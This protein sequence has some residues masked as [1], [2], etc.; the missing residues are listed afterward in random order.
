MSGGG[1]ADRT[2]GTCSAQVSSTPPQKRLLPTKY[3]RE[4][5]ELLDGYAARQGR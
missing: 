1:L 5:V 4:Y 3:L 2:Q